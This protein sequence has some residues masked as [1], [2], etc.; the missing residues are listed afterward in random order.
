MGLTVYEELLATRI[1][2]LEAERDRYKAALENALGTLEWYG[3]LRGVA[4][5]IREA[6]EEK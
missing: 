6:L 5:R 1:A 2:E 4:T 3:E